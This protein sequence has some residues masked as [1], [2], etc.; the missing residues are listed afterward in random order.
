MTIKHQ[1]FCLGSF[2]AVDSCIMPSFDGLYLQP[3]IT[4]LI[5]LFLITT[6]VHYEQANVVQSG[7]FRQ[8]DVDNTYCWVWLDLFILHCCSIFEPEN[9][10]NILLKFGFMTPEEA[11]SWSTTTAAMAMMSEQPHAYKEYHRKRCRLLR[12]ASIARVFLWRN[13]VQ[14]MIILLKRNLKYPLKSAVF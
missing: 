7:F 6:L 5:M 13:I 1:M 8:W 10:Q 12:P 14:I 3:W 9:Q 4:L 2:L 11:G